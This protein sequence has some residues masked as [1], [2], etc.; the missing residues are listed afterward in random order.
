MAG[1]QQPHTLSFHSNTGFS[2][3]RLVLSFFGPVR[4]T[5]II[6]VKVSAATL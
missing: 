1:G 6:S 2:I 3:T 4:L 5:H